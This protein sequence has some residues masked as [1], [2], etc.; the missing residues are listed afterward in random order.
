[1]DEN[2]KYIISTCNS[3][4]HLLLNIGLNKGT[5]YVIMNFIFRNFFIHIFFK[6][7]IFSQSFKYK[8]E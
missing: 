3:D 5:Y 6:P 8:I 4:M 1:M 2:N 7:Y